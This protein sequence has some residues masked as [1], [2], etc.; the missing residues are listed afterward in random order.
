MQ[1]T[2]LS[3]ANLSGATLLLASIHK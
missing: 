1:Q 2:D 3:A